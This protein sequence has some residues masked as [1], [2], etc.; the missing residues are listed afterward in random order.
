MK[1]ISIFIQYQIK[2]IEYLWQALSLKKQ[3]MWI[4]FFFYMY[5]FL[6][7]LVMIQICIGQNTGKTIIPTE[8]IKS[9]VQKSDQPL[10]FGRDSISLNAK[11]R[12]YG[13]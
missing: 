2:N 9:P 6:S 11:N 3:R 8:H 7:T 4:L 10:S 13:K 5:L 1:S 12:G